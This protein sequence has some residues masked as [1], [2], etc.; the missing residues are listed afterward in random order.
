MLGSFKKRQSAF[1]AKFQHDQE[2]IFKAH[3][4][5][6]KLFGLWAAAQ[7]GLDDE[8]ADVYSDQLVITDLDEKGFDNVV[9]LVK[10]DLPKVKNED[11]YLELD[12]CAHDVHKQLARESEDANAETA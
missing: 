7:L 4:K 1:E 6:S 5:T 8:E 2:M 3:A 11:L 12:R 10:K 9:A